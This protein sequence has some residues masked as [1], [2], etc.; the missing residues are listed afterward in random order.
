MDSD[1]GEILAIFFDLD[2]T[3]I[4]T[5]KADSL[6]CNKLIEILWE[7]YAIPLETAQLV[8]NTFL[9]SFRKCPARDPM[10]LDTWR[11][12]LWT[13]A[14]GDQYNKYSEQVY[15]QW[16]ELRYHYLALSPE[17]ISFL[18]L[19]RKTYMLA[20][21]TN[22]PSSAQWEKVDRLNLKSFFDI[23]LVSGDFP[24]EKPNA[25][26]FQEACDY[27]AIEPHRAI[28]VGDK[29]ETD[30]LGGIYAKL[31]ATIWTP[32]KMRILSATDPRPDYILDNVLDLLKLL[33]EISSSV[34][35]LQHK[36]NYLNSFELEDCNSNSS[37]GS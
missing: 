33:P 10:D 16:L 17:I 23:I 20:L 15:K 36:K 2:N 7:K 24:W 26:I 19:L 29:L 25:K 11:I 6:A 37:D 4:S 31:G 5:R 21:I 32:L 13:Q 27:L 9:K 35:G 30:I 3:L 22:G 8:C 28:M 34:S 18:R 14:L 12:L 1:N